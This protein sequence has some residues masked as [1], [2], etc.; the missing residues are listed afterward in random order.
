VAC[1]R[2]PA[3]R[4]EIVARLKAAFTSASC[5]LS[6]RW[7]P[8]RNNAPF[9]KREARSSES[10]AP[11]LVPSARH[12]PLALA[13]TA[14]P[15]RP[16]RLVLPRLYTLSTSTTRPGVGAPR[17]VEHH[18][19]PRRPRGAPSPSMACRPTSFGARPSVSRGVEQRTDDRRV[20]TDLERSA[21]EEAFRGDLEVG[22][23]ALIAPI[24][25]PIVMICAAVSP[26]SYG[27]RSRACRDGR[28]C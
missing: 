12:S 2:A 25:W 18:C 16:S 7:A 3:S 24:S 10:N 6:A 17:S 8:R 9:T 1:A 14:V 23:S 11:R 19:S 28:R 22:S 21:N 13:L 26:G 5:S 20:G 15:H 4:A 27:A